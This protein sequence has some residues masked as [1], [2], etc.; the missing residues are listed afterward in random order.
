M[1]PYGSC[2]RIA[3]SPHCDQ[4][5]WRLPFYP[6][7][8][9]RTLPKSPSA[10]KALCAMPL[11]YYPSP[12]EIVLCDYAT[13]FIPPEMVK[14]RPVVIVSPRLRKR[15]DLVAV[16]PLSTTAPNPA[17]PPALLRHRAWRLPLH[18]GSGLRVGD[19]KLAK[20]SC[21]RKGS[22]GN[23][24]AFRVSAQRS[25]MRAQRYAQAISIMCGR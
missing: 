8:P 21:V 9:D 3:E 25:G 13:G 7:N 20:P 15:G 17:E 2:S 12:G 23:G 14:L 16:V 19:N 1:L 5:V 24:G 22:I 4:P 6:S 10:N 18:W 11:S